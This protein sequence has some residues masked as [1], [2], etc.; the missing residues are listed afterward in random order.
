M[1]SIFQITY[2]H[3]KRLLPYRS[4]IPAWENVRRPLEI[5]IEAPVPG[6]WN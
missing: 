5:D 1:Q 6:G 4:T 3:M 2:E